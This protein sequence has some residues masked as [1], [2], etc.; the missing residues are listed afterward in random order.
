MKIDI[1]GRHMDVTEAMQDHVRAKLDRVEKHFP[2][3]VQNAHVILAMEAGQYLCEM[4]IPAAKRHQMIGK[5]TDLNDMYAA[6]DA[7][8]DKLT[9]QI[10]RFKER[11]KDHRHEKPGEALAPEPDE[12][13]D[14]LLDEDA[15]DFEDE[16]AEIE[17]AS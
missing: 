16:D 7:A 3:G 8:A 13:V 11:L 9:R 17:D 14:D 15:E 4:V 5:A 6:I 1:S 10:T 12:D 2:D